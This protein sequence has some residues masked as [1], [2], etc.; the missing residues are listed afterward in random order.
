M[1]SCDPT[2][3][4]PHVS[5]VPERPPGDS[6]ALELFPCNDSALA[7]LTLL[8][9]VYSCIQFQHHGVFRLQ[10]GVLSLRRAGFCFQHSPLS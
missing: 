3:R 2:G 7:P 9:L 5:T 8:P 1:H 6:A 10:H 4:R